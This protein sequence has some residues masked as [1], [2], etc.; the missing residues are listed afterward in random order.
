MTKIQKEKFSIQAELI[1]AVV[2]SNSYK[3]PEV[4]GIKKVHYKCRSTYV[5][6]R[7]KNEYF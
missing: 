3:R 2:N 6:G 5:G 1:H 4:K 7:M